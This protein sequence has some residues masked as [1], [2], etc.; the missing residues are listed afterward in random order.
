[1]NPGTCFGVLK[2]VEY[3]LDIEKGVGG[4][5]SDYG[6]IVVDSIK[7]MRADDTFSPE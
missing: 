4:Q 2:N 6:N 5:I 7:H 1:M 3:N